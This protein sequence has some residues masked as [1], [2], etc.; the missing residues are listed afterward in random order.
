MTHQLDTMNAMV[1]SLP[2][3]IAVLRR[4]LWGAVVLCASVACGGCG[5]NTLFIVE[6]E[7]VRVEGQATFTRVGGEFVADVWL[8]GNLVLFRVDRNLGRERGK[9][10]T[11]YRIGADLKLEEA[12]KFDRTKTNDELV[13]EFVGEPSATFTSNARGIELAQDLAYSRSNARK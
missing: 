6:A 5:A 13:A 1:S 8:P 10:G 4:C 7:R 9:A 3:P 12:G 2:M 11:S